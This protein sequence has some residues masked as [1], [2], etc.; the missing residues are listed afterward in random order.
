MKKNHGFIT[1]IIFLFSAVN[2]ATAN[3]DYANGLLAYRFA[4]FELAYDEFLPE[5][6]KGHTQAQ[7][8][9]GEMYEGGMGLKQDSG[10]AIQWYEKAAVNDHH[11]AQANIAS[12]YQR[13]FGVKQDNK[14]AFKWYALAADNG[15]QIAQYELG[16]MYADGVWVKADH[17][18]ACKWLSIAAI[19]GEPDAPWRLEELVKTMTKQQ[20]KTGEQLAAQWEQEKR[21]DEIMELAW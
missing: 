16:K 9:L 8:Y 3:A 1:G 2:S 12:I 5:A 17:V 19:Y 20:I 4:N 10:I 11:V 18:K 14:K 6:M 15:N 13:G 7:Y 21:E